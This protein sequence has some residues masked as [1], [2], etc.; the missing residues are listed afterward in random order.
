MEEHEDAIVD[1]LQVM[2][3]LDHVGWWNGGAE[4]GEDVAALC[5]RGM[6]WVQSIMGEKYG[7]HLWDS[8]PTM[9]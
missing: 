2:E 5:L 9:K 3:E 6:V 7:S 1:I 4:I 8:T